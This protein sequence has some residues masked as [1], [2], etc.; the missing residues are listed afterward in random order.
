MPI[1]KRA[2]RYR[3]YPTPAQLPVLAQH[4]GSVRFIYNHMLARRQER[5]AAA[6]KCSYGDDASALTA[7]KRNPELS[8]LRD[9]SSVA[10]QQAVRNLDSAFKSFFNKRTKFP[11]FKSKHGEQR[12]RLMKNAFTLRDGSLTLAKMDAPLDVRWSRALSSAPSQVTVI[13]DAAGRYFVSLLCEEEIQPLRPSERTVAFDLGLSSFVTF[14][15]ERPAIEPPRFLAKLLER[16]RLLSQQLS[17]KVKG[18]KNRQKARAR[19]A[20][21]HARVRD[22]RQ[23]FL[24]K[25]SMT[26]I[27]ENQAVF[28]ENLNIKGMMRG[29]LSRSIGDAAWGELLRQLEYKAK[30]YGRTF[31]QAPANFASSKTCHCCGFKLPKLELSTRQWTCPECGVIHDRDKNAA[32]N[33]HIA[34]LIAT[35]TA[36]VAGT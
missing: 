26:L 16:I 34:G 10:L 21:L 1:I 20:R 3:F 35:R 31:W 14:S 2:Y 4:F 29:W 7:L 24:H 27:C 33:L 22:M 30:W 19:L 17:R 28:A 32:R 11:R 6:L 23:D 36:G 13:R 25:L 18:S 12:F 5:R 8:W 15:D 9:V